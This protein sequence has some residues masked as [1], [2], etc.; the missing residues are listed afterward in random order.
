LERGLFSHFEVVTAGGLPKLVET[1][2]R[3][4]ELRNLSKLRGKLAGPVIKEAGKLLF[5]CA[6]PAEERERV[7]RAV[8]EKGAL[9]QH[10]DRV[11]RGDIDVHD[12]V[13]LSARYAYSGLT[14]LLGLLGSLSE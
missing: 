5:V 12:P 8:Q 11:C 13:F 7:V 10:A 14:E 9:L 6:L 4:S 1:L 3:L 2:A